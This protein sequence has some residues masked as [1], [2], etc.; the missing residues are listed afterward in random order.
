MDDLELGLSESHYLLLYYLRS[1]LRWKYNICDLISESDCLTEQHESLASLRI[2]LS[3]Y[4]L[5]VLLQFQCWNSV[6]RLA[7]EGSVLGWIPGATS[8]VQSGCVVQLPPLISWYARLRCSDSSDLVFRNCS[9]LTR[10]QSSLISSNS[11]HPLASVS[12]SVIDYL[13]TG[14]VQYWGLRQK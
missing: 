10:I 8:V 5:L 13:G 4:W 12:R 2:F 11:T 9:H 7:V 1:D 6:E 14:V 3:N